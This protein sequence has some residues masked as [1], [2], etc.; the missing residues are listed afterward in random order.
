MS[1]ARLVNLLKNKY[2]VES[3]EERFPVAELFTDNSQTPGQDHMNTKLPFSAKGRNL[4]FV[5]SLCTILCKSWGNPNNASAT[6][7]APP[8]I[9]GR[10]T[11]IGSTFPVLIVNFA[12]VP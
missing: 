12:V 6:T 2:A 10:V 4:L 11:G 5:D 1:F 7:A 3:T 8:G 9:L